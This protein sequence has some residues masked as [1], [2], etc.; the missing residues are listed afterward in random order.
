MAN[1]TYHFHPEAELELNHAVAYYEESQPHLGMEFADE[2]FQ[3]IHRILDFPKAWQ[4]MHKDIRR[5]LTKRFPF[6]VIYYQKDKQ[7]VI[8]AVMQLNRKP[9]YWVSRK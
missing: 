3:T 9:N 6:G 4:P 5:C 7:I 1:L 2:V 8:L